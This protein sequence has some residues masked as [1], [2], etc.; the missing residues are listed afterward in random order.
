MTARPRSSSTSV[1]SPTP[2]LLL[3][4]PMTGELILDAG[5]IAEETNVWG[6]GYWGGTIYGFSAN[7]N[8][9]EITENDDGT[10]TAVVIENTLLAFYGAGS[11]T[12]APTVPTG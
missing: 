3:V 10:I 1:K 4:N 9:T 2:H 8:I 6:L 7:G 12:F 11:S 5:P